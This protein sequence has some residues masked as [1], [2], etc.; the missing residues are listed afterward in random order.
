M[1][2]P[3]FS[4]VTLGYSSFDL[5]QV[6]RCRLICAEDEA[7]SSWPLWV[8]RV[9][10]ENTC[11][12]S[13][14]WNVFR[15]IQDYRNTF[16]RLRVTLLPVAHVVVATTSRSWSGDPS[17]IYTGIQKIKS[18]LMKFMFRISGG[19]KLLFCLLGLV[20]SWMSIKKENVS[21]YPCSY[22]VYKI[23]ILTIIN[24]WKN[25]TPFMKD[26]MNVNL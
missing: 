13:G 3:R 22:L 9:G 21:L 6:G 26:K 11:I 18:L 23:F 19:H 12:V 8:M 1:V 17:S 16:L 4:C 5:P 24:D 15:V 2:N 7:N 10:F 14:K 20:H 25:W